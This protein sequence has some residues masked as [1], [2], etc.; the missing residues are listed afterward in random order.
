MSVHRTSVL[1]ICLSAVG[2]AVSDW[3][4]ERGSLM[5]YGHDG[6][7]SD[8]SGWHMSLEEP[9]QPPP[10]NGLGSTAFVAGVVAVVFA[11]VPIVG[12][13][14]AVPAAV[15]AI[16]LGLVGFD[17]AL[18]GIATNGREALVGSILGASSGVVLFLIFA[19]TAG[20]VD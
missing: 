1:H 17:R 9:S 10:R 18:R 2:C 6:R 20:P 5:D 7:D 11:F 15:L 19:A 13:F 4:Q 14:V 16:A 8:S 3:T 12:E